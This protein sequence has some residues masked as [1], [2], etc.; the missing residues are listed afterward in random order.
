[1][2]QNQRYLRFYSLN[3]SF[4]LK[5]GTFITHNATQS[6]T[7]QRFGLVMLEMANVAL[8][9]SLIKINTM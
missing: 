6:L 2:D 3:S 8:T 5:S 7:L 9:M 4:L 1:M